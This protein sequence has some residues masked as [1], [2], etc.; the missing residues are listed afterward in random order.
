MVV[1]RAGERRDVYFDRVEGMEEEG[2]G[3]DGAV[4][5]AVVVWVLGGGGAE[6]LVVVVLEEVEGSM[7]G[8][9]AEGGRAERSPSIC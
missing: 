7:G 6:R 4:V 8:R 2:M 3:V 9:A 5:G 1:C